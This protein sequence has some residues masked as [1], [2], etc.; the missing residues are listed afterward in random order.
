MNSVLVKI[1]DAG[2]LSWVEL[3]FLADLGLPGLARVFKQTAL[4]VHG[5][6]SLALAMNR[7]DI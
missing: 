7:M 1:G 4:P 6:T 5:S 2:A 3:P